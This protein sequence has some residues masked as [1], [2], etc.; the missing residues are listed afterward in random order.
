[1]GARGEFLLL[2]AVLVFAVLISVVAQAQVLP[3][4]SS[5]HHLWDAANKLLFASH[6]VLEAVDFGITHRN[7]SDGGREMDSMARRC[8]RVER[9]ASWFSSEG[10]WRSGWHQLSL[11]QNWAPQT[12][13][14]FSGLRQ[15][16]FC[17]WGGLHLRSPLG[18]VVGRKRTDLA[19]GK[20][21]VLH[22]ASLRSG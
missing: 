2:V 11:A 6:G 12:G 13:A 10:K 4:G 9:R 20:L 5:Q 17:L 18:S 21:S 22:F 19:A 8:V 16:G 7:L 3:G 1:M 14:G 15:R